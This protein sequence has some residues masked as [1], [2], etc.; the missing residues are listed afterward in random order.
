MLTLVLAATILS[1]VPSAIDKLQLPLED[2]AMMGLLAELEARVARNEQI[3]DSVISCI[4]ESLI[5]TGAD[6]GTTGVAL[7]RCP[8]CGESNP[9]GVNVETRVGLKFA[10]TGA[11]I[12]LCLLSAK[13][14]QTDPTSSHRHAKWLSRALRLLVI[15][16]NSYAAVMGKPLFRFGKGGA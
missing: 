16:N 10:Q 3:R 4:S 7:D 5:A 2:P 1:S 15:V 11:E 14:M 12:G 13:H 6:L 8:T 9:L